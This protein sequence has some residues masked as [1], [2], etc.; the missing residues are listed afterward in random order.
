M[1]VGTHERTTRSF[2]VAEAAQ[3]LLDIHAQPEGSEPRVDELH[4]VL[5]DASVTIP[6][7]EERA[8]RVARGCRNAPLKALVLMGALRTL[9]RVRDGSL[10]EA[11]VETPDEEVQDIIDTNW[12]DIEK[13]GLSPEECRLLATL[14]QETNNDFEYVAQWPPVQR[15]DLTK[16][17]QTYDGEVGTTTTALLDLLDRLPKEELTKNDEHLLRWLAGGRPHETSAYMRARVTNQSTVVMVFNELLGVQLDNGGQLTG[18]EVANAILKRMD[19]AAALS[20]GRRDFI[21]RV[22]GA[23]PYPPGAPTTTDGSG[24]YSKLTP[25]G[26]RAHAR[27]SGDCVAYPLL[28][29]GASDPDRAE[30]LELIGWHRQTTN[31]GLKSPDYPA[32]RIRS[33]ETAV[34]AGAAIVGALWP[35]SRPFRVA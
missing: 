14:W 2:I 6:R 3:D 33:S 32:D 1:I 35:D 12:P 8:L 24:H 13:A 16:I 5:E 9:G 28:R 34:R 27:V 19:A 29:P 23:C 21:T 15:P 7:P 17:W 22:I 11:A 31:G 20:G 26:K 18:P 30:K 25:F 10:P 4:S